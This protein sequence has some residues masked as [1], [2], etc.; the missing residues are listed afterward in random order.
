MTRFRSVRDLL[1]ARWRWFVLSIVGLLLSPVL[2]LCV[3]AALTELPAQL[4]ERA[5]EQSLRVQDRDGNL[6]REVRT[7]DGEL[8][9]WV[10]LDEVPPFFIDALVAVEDRR[11]YDHLGVDPL[12]VVRAAGQWIW[13]RRVI[14][15]ASTLSMQLARN[16][17]PRERTVFGKFCEMALAL[18]IEASLSK[19]EIL[20]QYV[21][22]VDFGPNLRGLGAASQSYFA[23]TPAQLSEPELALLAGLPQRPAAFA[24]DAHSERAAKRRAHVLE[25]L[26]AMKKVAP[27]ELETFAAR[28]IAVVKRRS[29]FGAPHF[30]TA[31]IGGRLDALG[32]KTEPG[33]SRVRTTIDGG[34]QRAAEA[35]V[36]RGLDRLREHEVSAAAAL[37]IDNASGDILAYVGSPDFYNV[38]NQGQVDG[39]RALRQPGSTLKPFLYAAAIEELGYDAATPLADV[40]LRIETPQGAYTPRNY[41]DRFRGPVRLRDA[42]A[43][44][45]NVPAVRTAVLLGPDTLLRHLHGFGFDSLTEGPEHY[46]P[47]LALG[48]GEVTLLELVRAY[49]TLARGGR[50]GALRAVVE[51]EST[52]N[53]VA[54]PKTASSEVR[55]L[56]ERTAALIT[57]VLKDPAARAQTFGR[58]SSLEFDFDV[59]VKTGTSKGYRDNWAVGYTDRFT[60][61]VWVGNFDGRPMQNVSGATGAAPIFAAIL[62]A[63]TVEHR[64]GALPLDERANTS[65]QGASGSGFERAE[66][67]PL[68]G[69]LRTAACPKGVHEWL[70]HAAERAHCDWHQH[71]P[72]DRRNDL[73]AGPGCPSHVVEERAVELLPAEF[74]QWAHA[75]GRP[76]AP[77]G[78][79]PFCP[80]P[81]SAAPG[82]EIAILAP[83]DGA[84]FV[85]DPDR[86]RDLQ[87][88]RIAVA[89]AVLRE[90]P[91]LEIDG[92][93]PVALDD[94]LRFDWLMQ[95]GEH[96]FVAIGEG[97][98]RSAPVRVSVRDAI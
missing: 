42:L 69:L 6:L 5:P 67:C 12:A 21:N 98:E 29:A 17:R 3:S 87:R 35:A 90:R 71:L 80:L 78:S 38:P 49:S 60:L 68:S 52:E 8:S 62:R 89:G 34:L 46:G 56:P 51:T 75:T 45:L 24:L 22:R 2:T 70:P 39:V 54:Q 25:R 11:F 47:A 92:S 55:V 84:R 91:R 26:H 74:T 96:E 97:G 36:S 93:A 64:P 48:D 61:G 85:L 28:P 4:S 57:D 13:H 88:L 82:D 23:R 81:E 86:P 20:E 41:D 10:S 59:A 95:P 27:A 30:V 58:G 77:S 72:I 40:E 18:R 50:E 7:A 66:V 15:G 9:R 76:R 32:A 63:V 16:L 94:S 53:G 43:N 1:R 19:R 31:L 33:A 83:A 44:S 14:S 73:L 65:V 37:L 79:S